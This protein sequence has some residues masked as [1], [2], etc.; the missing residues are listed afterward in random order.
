LKAKN[1]AEGN[2][3]FNVETGSWEIRFPGTAET[4]T[5]FRSRKEAAL[6]IAVFA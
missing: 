2:V 6:F 1:K 3:E 5:G 4:F